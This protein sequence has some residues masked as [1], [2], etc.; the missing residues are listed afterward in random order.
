MSMDILKKDEFKKI[1]NHEED[2]VI[3]LY[4]PTHEKG[5]EVNE[6]K[7]RLQ[8]KNVL[9]NIEEQLVDKGYSENEIHAYLN[10]AYQLMEDRNFW[11]YQ[12]N[13][14]ALFTGKS[15]FMKFRLP[16]ETGDINYIGPDFYIKPLLPLFYEN[17][18]FYLLN[19]S[20]DST[21]FYQCDRF[22]CNEIELSEVAPVSIDEALQWDDPEKSVQHHYGDKASQSPI[23]HGQGVT[24]DE[25]DKNMMRYF[26]LIDNGISELVKSRQYP[27]VITGIE[28]ETV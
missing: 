20:K 21:R 26:K 2:E 10:D 3:T 24:R 12:S 25:E 23:Y 16:I 13:T 6:D 28:K 19:L 4:F 9:K 14:L 22:Y 8:F 1:I 18:D 15:F 7:D 5:M 11:L 27:L 17:G